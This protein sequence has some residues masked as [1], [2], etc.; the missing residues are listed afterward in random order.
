MEKETPVILTVRRLEERM[1]LEN[2]VLAVE[3]LIKKI[4]EKKFQLIIVG[5][6]SL[7]QKLEEL[8]T[9]KNLSKVIKLSG[10]G[11]RKNLPLYFKV[12]DLFVL[13][14]LSLIH[15]SEPTRPY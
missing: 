12:A 6:G 1:G 2:L 14:T 13:P 10:L 15:I 4:P 9:T 5:K 11:S 8:I 7:H 3:M